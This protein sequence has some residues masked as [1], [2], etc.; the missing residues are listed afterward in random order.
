MNI[1]K[2]SG[3]LGLTQP[4]H[5][6]EGYDNKLYLIEEY[7]NNNECNDIFRYDIINNNLDKLTTTPTNMQHYSTCI[8]NNK[9]YLVGGSQKGNCNRRIYTY[10]LIKD[11]WSNDID[12]PQ[13]ICCHTSTIYQDKMYIVGGKINNEPIDNIYEYNFTTK[14]WNKKKSLILSTYMHVTILFEDKLYII[15]G[16]QY[17]TVS[18]SISVYDLKKDN[19]D[20]ETPMPTP[21]YRQHNAFVFEEAIHVIGG[22]YVTT[23]LNI[24]YMYNLSLRKWIEIQLPSFALNLYTATVYK[25]K[26]YIISINAITNKKELYVYDHENDD[27]IKLKEL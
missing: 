3:L 12:L 20:W 16:I 17:D 19:V 8:Y 23:I 4:I 27:W 7:Q 26:F 15:G 10:D 1:S 6:L 11:T 21:M 22:W 9:L 2:Y 14:L 13:D 25:D 18:A 24:M 5:Q